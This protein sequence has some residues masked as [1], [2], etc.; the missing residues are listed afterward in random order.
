MVSQDPVTTGEFVAAARAATRKPLIAKLT[1]DVTDIRPIAQAAER[2]GADI[3]SLCNTYTGMSLDPVTGHSRIGSP[4]GGLSGPAIRPLSLYRL[5]RAREAVRCPLIGVGGIV[6]VDDVL[7]YFHAGASAV[8]IGTG[9]FAH[10]DTA[11][12]VA[13]GLRRHFE[14]QGTA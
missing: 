3:L 9:T 2:A 8:A 11:V 7:E 5:W 6:T 10:P 4:T 14:R 1:P 13:R 12:R